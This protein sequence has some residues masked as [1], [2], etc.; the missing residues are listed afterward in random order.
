[1][2]DAIAGHA[3]QTYDA[4]EAFPGNFWPTRLVNLGQSDS[5]EMNNNLRN[6][7]SWRGVAFNKSS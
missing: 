7:W 4:I 1:M 3:T 2:T 6:A 5:R